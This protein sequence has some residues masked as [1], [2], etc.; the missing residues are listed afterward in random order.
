MKHYFT[1]SF[2]LP[3]GYIVENYEF[4]E[5]KSKYINLKIDCTII[6]NNNV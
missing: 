5:E 1:I 3:S 2:N 6:S 4:Y